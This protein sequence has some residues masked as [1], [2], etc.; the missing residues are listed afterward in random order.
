MVGVLAVA[1]AAPPAI[2]VPRIAVVAAGGVRAWYYWCSMLLG[3]APFL[4]AGGFVAAASM[5]WEA[6]SAGGRLGSW[7][8]IAFAMLFP[9][10]DCAMNAYAASLRAARPA[11]AAFAVVW[12]SC[13]NPLA[14]VFTANILGPRLVA[15][16]LMCGAVAAGLTAAAWSR[17]GPL[18]E[19]HACARPTDLWESFTRSTGG[20]V[21]SFSLAAAVSAMFLVHSAAAPPLPAG[22]W[23]A[24]LTGA[25]LSPCS[26]ADALLARALYRAAPDQLAFLIAAQC[27]DVR[28]I[29]LLR[30]SFGAART[31][32]ACIAAALACALGCC[33]AA[34]A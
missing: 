26:S 15:Y 5:R 22:P 13:C 6:A 33:I 23:L 11:L 17:L 19:A 31:A 1:A 34:R 20:A 10:C 25:L 24:A 32:Q 27:L 3:A 9:G 4:A 8:R 18:P 16:R 7:T 29:A 28:Q 21:T 12:G 30:R 14:L 2:A